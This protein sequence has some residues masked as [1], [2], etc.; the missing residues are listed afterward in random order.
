MGH[1][2]LHNRFAVRFTPPRF[3]LE[4]SDEIGKTRTRVVN[5]TVPGDGDGD[6][7]S[8]KNIEK[9]TTD[10]LR[11]FPRRLQCSKVTKTQVE[12]LVGKMMDSVSSV[13]PGITAAM[14]VEDSEVDY[15]EDMFEDDELE[16]KPKNRMEEKFNRHQRTSSRNQSGGAPVRSHEKEKETVQPAF[17]PVKYNR[18]DWG[19]SSSDSDIDGLLP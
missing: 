8:E 5:V 11:A 6:V 16:V 18:E 10:V 2:F 1:D 19:D 12:R 15:D 17:V 9:V 14:F 7:S 13:A 4:Y 3:V